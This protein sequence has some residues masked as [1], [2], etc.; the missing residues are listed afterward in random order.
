MEIS[1][2]DIF[3]SDTILMDIA[4]TTKEDVFSELA[5][6]IKAVHPESDKKVILAALWEREKKLSTGITSG[7]AIP[8]A[9][10]SGIGTTAGALG[11]SR[12]GI[13]YDALDKKPV[14]VIFML[15]MSEGAKENHLHIL[16]QIF[17]LV[18]T[19]AL[20]L[21]NNAKNAQEVHAILSKFN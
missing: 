9:I 4:S 14:H 13:E 2:G 17:S 21:I 18:R 7:V 16:D 12:A 5:D 6:A 8:H 10:C 15:V 20:T 19:D 1:L 3:T 11:I